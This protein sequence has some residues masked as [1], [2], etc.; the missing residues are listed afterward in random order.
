MK[1]FKKEK[2][3]KGFLKN[4][5]KL[6]EKYNVAFIHRLDF[7]GGEPVNNMVV[8]KREGG[9]EYRAVAT[10]DLGYAFSADDVKKAY[11]GKKWQQL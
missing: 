6:L 3:M 11:G 1:L 8:I 9:K 10:V 5:A 4:F 7:E 2:T